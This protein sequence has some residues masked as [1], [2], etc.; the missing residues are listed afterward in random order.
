MIRVISYIFAFALIIGVIA[1]V[2]RSMK[3]KSPD[4]VN[5]PV[6]KLGVEWAVVQLAYS[7]PMLVILVLAGLILV[8]TIWLGV[9]EILPIDAM[10]PIGIA[11]FISIAIAIVWLSIP[12]IKV[13]AKAGPNYGAMRKYFADNQKECVAEALKNERVI[14]AQKL[15]GK[16]LS[17]IIVKMISSNAMKY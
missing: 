4:L 17:K 5:L 14:S 13:S 10:L 12:G 16:L 15:Q 9:S 2:R 11:L 6:E 7:G 3:K 8:T 1:L